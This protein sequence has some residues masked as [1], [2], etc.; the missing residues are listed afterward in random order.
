ML[1][2][3]EAILGFFLYDLI[4]QLF[5]KYRL[6]F[7]YISKLCLWLFIIVQKNKD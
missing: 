4:L 7:L 3:S 2:I 5:L 6:Y 1:M